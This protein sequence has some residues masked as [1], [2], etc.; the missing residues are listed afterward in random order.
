MYNELYVGED[1]LELFIM[2]SSVLLFCLSQGLFIKITIVRNY[3]NLPPQ[4]HK[5]LLKSGSQTLFFYL[6]IGNFSATQDIKPP[7]TPMR[8]NCDTECA[9]QS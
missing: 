2:S 1:L 9:I 8:N 3:T 7:F 6:A 5:M 4:T